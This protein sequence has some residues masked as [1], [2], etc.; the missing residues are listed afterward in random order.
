M[1]TELGYEITD[2]AGEYRHPDR[3]AIFVGDLIDRGDEHQRV[4]EIVKAMVDAG[5]AR[6][7]MGNHEF[8]ALA[9][10]AEW[11]EGSGKYLRPH[12]D[13]DNPWSEKNTRQH[14]AFLDQIT[15]EQRRYYLDW[16]ATLPIWLDL[17]G[18][19]VVH[20]CWHDESIAVVQERCGSAA[21]FTDVARLVAASDKSDPLYRAVETL[22]KGPEIS[23]VDYGQPEYR[24]KDDVP[25]A[26]AR[27]RWW[28]S[29]AGTLRDAAVM[30]SGIKTKDRKPYPELPD[31]ELRAD[32]ASYVYTGEVPV[33]YGH[34]WRQGAPEP[35]QDWTA[36]TACVDFSAVKPGG[37]L[38]A[39]RWS[40]ESEIDPANYH[41][42][43]AAWDFP[44]LAL[45]WEA[46]TRAIVAGAGRI[47]ALTDAEVESEVLPN[48]HKE[49]IV[50]RY[51]YRAFWSAED[52]MYVGV[53]AEFPHMSWLADSA[54]EALAGIE[55]I[56]TDIVA[57]ME[58]NGEF[59]P[60]P[61][62]DRP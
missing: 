51:T 53:V 33:F 59:V 23:L 24:D 13:P 43:G 5:S 34:Y 1:L 41:Q 38:T 25:R 14:Q 11:P 4:L 19:R 47:E 28:D 31:T 26:S 61:F 37:A 39:Y 16:F 8:N 42:L 10:H 36:R 22:L 18:L 20:A 45:V 58:A 35:G 21:P 56:V 30:D 54:R 46:K 50:S 32:A 29:E 17:G 9:Y 62:A 48:L 2:S 55:K 7:V 57:D 27:I 49:R 40:G 12:D 60:V 3:Q 6:I 44:S 52:E 15:G